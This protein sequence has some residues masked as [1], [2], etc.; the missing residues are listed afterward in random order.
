[1]TEIQEKVIA[2]VQIQ[3]KPDETIDEEKI[4]NLV[5]IFRMI[6]PLTD[7][8]AEEV[9]A[10]LQTRLAIKMD[11]GAYVKEKNHISWY[12]A[13]KG[14]IDPKFWTRYSTFLHKYAGF[15]SE[16][17]NAIDAATDEMMDLLSNPKSSYEFQRRGLVIG[18]VQSGKTSTYLALMN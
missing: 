3:I 1:M 9:V 13:A 8:E 16:V 5:N 15:N 2:Q 6:N 11:R 17:V 7:E 14:K 10:E 18:D 4:K 12:Y